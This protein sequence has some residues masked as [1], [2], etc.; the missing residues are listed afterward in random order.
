MKQIDKIIDDL[1]HKYS[2]VEVGKGVDELELKSV[3]KKLSVTFPADYKYFLMKYGYLASDGPDILGLGCDPDYDEYYSML[4]FTLYDRNGEVPTFFTPR[5]ANT[6]IVG[7]YGGGGHFFLH[8]E[9]SSRSG[10]VEL[11]LDE[12]NGKPDKLKWQ[13]FTEYLAH[14]A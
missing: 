1:K 8:C 7:A 3:E 13:S 10:A 2:T 14:Y 5:P 12:L 4:F 11:L 6:V 9:E